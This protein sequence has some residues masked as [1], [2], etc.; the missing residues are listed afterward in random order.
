MPL[1]SSGSAPRRTGSQHGAFV[2]HLGDV[3]DGGR[4]EQYPRYLA[5]RKA[6]TKTVLEIPGNHDPADLFQR[7]L[8]SRWTPSTSRIG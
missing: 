8:R 4:E 7:H 3:V 5:G 2:L 1:N 6:I